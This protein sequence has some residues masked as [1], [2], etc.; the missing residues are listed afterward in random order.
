MNI[1]TDYQ[2]S[3]NTNNAEKKIK[4]M[5]GPFPSTAQYA[6]KHKEE[7]HTSESWGEWT[8]KSFPDNKHA[9]YFSTSSGLGVGVALLK[10]GIPVMS[11]TPLELESHLV[12]QHSAKG[13]VVVAGLGLAMI[14]LSLLKKKEITSLTVLEIDNEIISMFPSILTG[15]SN[16]LWTD[17]IKTGRLK[18]IQTDCKL[19]FNND[20]LK[21]IGKVDYLWAD[22]WNELCSTEA[23][24][25][26]QNLSNQL[27][28]TQCDF[29]GAEIE[30]A[31][32]TLKQG[33][34]MCLKT[35]KEVAHGFKL[36]LSILSMDGKKLKMYAELSLV[37]AKNIYQQEKL[38]NTKKPSV[39]I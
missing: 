30:I 37:A 4:K 34:Y 35:F 39:T 16:K 12:A 17:N 2:F 5:F 9:G 1:P 24:S 10:N 15:E 21:Q 32:K 38:A 14:T 28:P 18:I 6:I 8:L 27:K 11:Q 3:F 7:K 31:L 26:T 25:I 13:R 19:P 22:I 20:I 33:R 36:P 23:L 29:W